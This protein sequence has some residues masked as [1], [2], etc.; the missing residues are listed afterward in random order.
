MPDKLSVLRASHRVLKPDGRLGFLVIAPGD[1]LTASELTRMVDEDVGPDYLDAGPGYSELMN[2]AG[3]AHVQIVDV[4]P[5]YLATTEAWINERR[6]EADDLRVVWGHENFDDR[7]ASQ[8]RSLGAIEDG[9]LRR[10][11][12][13]GTRP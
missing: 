7:Q 13:I 1:N 3:F 2:Q 5:Q 8:R 4:T 10:Y 9:R 6:A 11:L 12:V